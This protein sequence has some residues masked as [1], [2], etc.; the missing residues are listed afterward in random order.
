MTDQWLENLL[1]NLPN[2]EIFYLSRC[3]SLKIVKISSNGLKYLDIVACDNLIEV[4]LDTPNLL[5]FSS[6]VRYGKDIV[7]P[8][9]TFKLKASHMLEANL[10]LIPEITLDTY[11]YNKFMKSLANFNHSKAI[12]F[13]CEND[14]V[15]VIPKYKRENLIPPLYCTKHLY[16]IMNRWNHSVVDLVD[17]LLWISPQLDTLSF[18]RALDIKILKFTY[19]DAAD[20]EP[21]CESLPWKYWRH[22]LKKVKLQNFTCVELSKLRNYFLTNTD[23][24]EIIE[25]PPRCNIC[26]SQKEV[27]L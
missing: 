8:L 17:S 22:E 14:K 21:C 16:V 25:D 19:R 23:I 10:N 3:W 26:S 9:P 18:G 13:R 12:T 11:W 6:E 24:L 2:L 15:I 27:R 5:R 1:P 20:E 7:E 4:D